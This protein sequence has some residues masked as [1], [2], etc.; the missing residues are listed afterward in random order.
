MVCFRL[1][2]VFME[3]CKALVCCREDSEV[4]QLKIEVKFTSWQG[5]VG[6]QDCGYQKIHVPIEVFM[7][8]GYGDMRDG[9]HP[10][11]P[12]AQTPEALPAAKPTTTFFFSQPQELRELW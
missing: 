8:I 1:S 4:S 10:T 9:F 12:H 5:L 11:T 2:Q 7:A 3:I 6:F